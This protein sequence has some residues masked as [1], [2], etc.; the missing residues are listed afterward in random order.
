MTPL[1]WTMAVIGTAFAA[2]VIAVIW[3]DVLRV[4]AG[5]DSFSRMLLTASLSR[6][7]VPFLVGAALGLI[8][9]L[10]GGHFFLPLED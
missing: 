10:L 8:A 4:L 3:W 1:G 9:G 2:G 5:K 7:W 6:P